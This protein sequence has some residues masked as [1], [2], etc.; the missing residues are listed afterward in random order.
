MTWLAGASILGP[1]ILDALLFRAQPYYPV[2]T[3][4]PGP[5][6]SLT[7]TLRTADTLW[8]RRLV[9]RLGGHGTVVSPPELART[10]T[11]GAAAA[12]AAYGIDASAPS[13]DG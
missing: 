9:W 3:V 13:A 7:V 4:E 11:D 1:H 2:E 8:L 6:G 5:D 10:V 12:L